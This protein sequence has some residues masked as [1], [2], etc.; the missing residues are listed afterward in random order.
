MTATDTSM[1]PAPWR[2]TWFAPRQTI[3]AVIA[4]D[5]RRHVLLLAVLTGITALIGE[6][7]AERLSWLT[8]SWQLLSL[9]I[10]GGALAGVISL[11]LTGFLIQ[12]SSRL[13]GGGGSRADTRAA[14]AWSS[15][16]TIAILAL[17]L[18]ALVLL[19]L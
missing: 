9:T 8:S 17:Y 7:M 1:T 11:Y 15:M 10:I 19:V 18:A 16:P 4:H 13:L 2:T 12:W 3:A 5:P 6:A 14:I